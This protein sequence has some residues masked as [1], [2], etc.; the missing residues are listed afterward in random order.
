LAGTI[1]KKRQNAEDR[2]D[3]KKAE[4]YVAAWEKQ[5]PKVAPFFKQRW[6]DL[7]TSQDS[8][9]IERSSLGRRRVF[10]GGNTVIRRQ[11]RAQVL[12]GFEADMLKQA[13]VRINGHFRRDGLKSRIV[14]AIHDSLWVHA[15]VEEQEIAKETLVNEMTH[16]LPMTVPV[17]VDVAVVCRTAH[18]HMTTNPIFSEDAFT[19]HRP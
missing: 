13:M 4:T 9:R 1:N 3:V 2:I 5:F 18:D 14:M 11:H 7:K 8:T 10:V 19:P 15:P 6:K 17:A 12:Q 16:A